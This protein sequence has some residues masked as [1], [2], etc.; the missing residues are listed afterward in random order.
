MSFRK[1]IMSNADKFTIV[2]FHEPA[3]GSHSWFGSGHGSNRFIRER[4]V[5][6]CEDFDVEMVLCGHNHWYER[7]FANGIYH[8]TTGGGGAPLLPVSPFPSDRIEGSEVNEMAYHW[9]VLSIDEDSVRDY[10]RDSVRVDVIQHET[11][12][13]LDS[14]EVNKR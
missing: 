9:C 8:I 1:E 12:S 11:H 14:F 4:Y 2:L 13:L 10:V 5:S 3:Y 7:V 6:L